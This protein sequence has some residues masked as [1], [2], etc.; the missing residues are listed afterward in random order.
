[1][2][3]NPFPNTFLIGVQKAG[4]TTLNDWLGQHPQ[5][6]CYK[7]L[8]DVHLFARF[9]SHSEIMRR[10]AQEPALYKGEPIVLQSGVNYVFYPHFL[11]K[12]KEYN[13]SAK[14]LLILRNPV[15]RAF[16]AYSYLQ[17]MMREERSFKRSVVV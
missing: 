6:F 14:L 16:S 5:I 3:S 15:E 8:K 13:P 10:L 4:T 7:S 17:K 11:Q 9:K 12:I 2:S 1:M